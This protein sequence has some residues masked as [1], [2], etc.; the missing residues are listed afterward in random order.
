MCYPLFSS[1]VTDSGR[2]SGTWCCTWCRGN[3]GSRS[4]SRWNCNPSFIRLNIFFSAC[5]WSDSSRNIDQLRSPLVKHR[6]MSKFMSGVVADPFRQPFHVLTEVSHR[7]SWEDFHCYPSP[8]SWCWSTLGAS[9]CLYRSLALEPRSRGIGCNRDKSSSSLY[10]TTVCTFPLNFRGVAL[11][12]PP[13][14]LFSC[15][16]STNC[17]YGNPT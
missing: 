1:D 6:W 15:W 12:L 5:T 8:E 14:V 9:C 7:H 13:A 11:A 16:N 10:A 17:P 4:G 3:T 2:H